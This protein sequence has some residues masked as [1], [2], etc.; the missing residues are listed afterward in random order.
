MS[1]QTLLKT[2][3]NYFKTY[4]EKTGHGDSEIESILQEFTAI[5]RTDLLNK[6]KLKT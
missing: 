4:L 3:L 2:I 5:N 1:D 6:P